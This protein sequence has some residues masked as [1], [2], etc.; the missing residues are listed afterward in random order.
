[1]PSLNKIT[2]F[3]LQTL[4]HNINSYM[5]YNIPCTLEIA[6]I[7]VENTNNRSEIH[8]QDVIVH[9]YNGGL[10][11]EDSWHPNIF[12]Y[13]SAHLSHLSNKT[14]ANL[15]NNNASLNVNNNDKSQKHGMSEFYARLCILS[16]TC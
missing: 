7:I 9:S 2:L 15:N 16:I 3:K 5:H 11:C 1:M 6:A 10:Q 13:N 14:Q 8:N 12:I 4:L